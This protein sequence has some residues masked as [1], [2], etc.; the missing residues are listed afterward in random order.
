MR[1]KLILR[2]I[3]YNH[4]RHYVNIS[5]DSHDYEIINIKS[6]DGVMY[7]W[8]SVL[9]HNR[10]SSSWYETLQ[11]TII[12]AFYHVFLSVEVDKSCISCSCVCEIERE[13]VFK[14][15]MLL[16]EIYVKICLI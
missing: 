11:G 12:P 10:R 6:L 15:C 7:A 5:L 4:H 3:G 9:P 13:K 14:I 1:H 8:L 2:D 16:P